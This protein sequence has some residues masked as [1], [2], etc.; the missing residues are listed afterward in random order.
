MKGR[1]LILLGVFTFSV[2]FLFQFPAATALTLLNMDPA[3]VQ[4]VSGTVWR[5]S[6]DRI[7]ISPE[8]QLEDVSWSFKPA[9]LIQAKA[10]AG[11]DF[12]YRG[13]HGYVVAAYSVFGK[14]ALSSGRYSTSAQALEPLLPL[15]IAEF[16]GEIT[17]QLEE[18]SMKGQQF[19]KA[20]GTLVW[21]E[22]RLIRPA[23]ALLGQVTL[24]VLPQGDNHL[25]SLKNTGGELRLSGDIT[26]EENKRYNATIILKPERNASSE[27]VNS[28]RALGRRQSDGS[29]RIRQQGNLAEI[30]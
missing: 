30:L 23:P 13:G 16:R 17:L 8:E 22:A 20:E 29:Y 10:G 1:Y 18:L 6:A 15:P 14:A 25:I 19:H 24:D 3:Q 2:A 12:T 21:N 5:G 7:L 11:L 9:L 26:L 27:L 28:L 4:N